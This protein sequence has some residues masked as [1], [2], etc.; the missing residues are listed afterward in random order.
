MAAVNLG[1]CFYVQAV[2]GSLPVLTGLQTR[3]EYLSKKLDYYPCARFAAEHLGRN[4]RILLVGEQRG[5]YVEQP[6]VATSVMAPNRFVLAA[7]EA[8][9]ADDLAR[10][11]RSEGFAHMLYVPSEARRLGDGYRIFA[12]TERGAANWNGLRSRLENLYEEPGRCA[13][14]R[15]Q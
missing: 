1:I 9:G 12:F 4:D 13:L 5:Y 15:I 11:L 10:R 6:H 14:L 3:R 8:A 2:F 7:N